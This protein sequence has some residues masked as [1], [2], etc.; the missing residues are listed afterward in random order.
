MKLCSELLLLQDSGPNQ[1][2]PDSRYCLHDNPNVKADWH[3][4]MTQVLVRV[5]VFADLEY[6]DQTVHILIKSL[7]Y[8][9]NTSYIQ[10][11]KFKEI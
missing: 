11:Y 3:V 4:G 8:I 6:A 9:F 2:H 10:R 1:S 7:F 5:P